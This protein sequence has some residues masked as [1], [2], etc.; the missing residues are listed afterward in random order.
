MPAGAEVF[1]WN[2]TNY[3]RMRSVDALSG[4]KQSGIGILAAQAVVY[5]YSGTRYV[6]HPTATSGS[7]VP[8]V[9]IASGFGSLSGVQVII[10]GGAGSPNISGGVTV[11]GSVQVSGTVTALF[12]LQSG[13]MVVV[14]GGGAG[15]SG[16]AVSV[17]GDVVTVSGNVVY[18]SGAV[19]VSSGG[20]LPVN[21][22]SGAYVFGYQFNHISGANLTNVQSGAS[23]IHAV[24]INAWVSGGQITVYD[25]LSG[26]N[27]AT[28]LATIDFT[29]VGSLATNA[30]APQ[31]MVYDAYM[32]SGIV[33]STSGAAIDVTVLYRN[34]V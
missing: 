2:G 7:L 29:E 6:M 13:L 18:I 23:V 22:V 20:T 11:S 27:A 3:D 15:I 9:A 4:G 16:V 5:D 21:P 34:P 28:I 26:I 24:N 30:F 32:K 10:S 19:G 8:L 14:S 12:G 25:S 33:V 17:S 1:L 31:T